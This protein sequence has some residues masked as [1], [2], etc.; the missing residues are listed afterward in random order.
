[1]KLSMTTIDH[2]G[3]SRPS[4]HKFVVAGICLLLAV[5]VALVAWKEMKS[6]PS[7]SPGPGADAALSAPLR[8]RPRSVQRL[9][10]AS[11]ARPAPGIAAEP[12]IEATAADRP[13]VV[14]L[15]ATRFQIRRDALEAALAR[16]SSLFTG[17]RLIPDY[18]PGAPPGA[19]LFGV[20]PG[21]LLEDMG[22]ESGD[23]ITDLDGNPVDD[24]EGAMDRAEDLR[25]I[26]EFSIGIERGDGERV[27]LTY[28]VE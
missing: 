16:P 14:A 11:T 8:P 28:V 13:A 6:G 3:V 9:P 7:A 24:P 4:S 21:S 12:G 17:A 1:M 25:G 23:R 26:D 5:I 10:E 15:S 18:A 19:R 27:T 22:L 20:P 2:K